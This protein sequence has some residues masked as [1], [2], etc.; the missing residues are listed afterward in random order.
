MEDWRCYMCSHPK[1]REIIG[2]G[3]V[4]FEARFL[5]SVEPNH[6]ELGLPEP[7]GKHR[8]DFVALRA[9]GSACRLHPSQRRDA[10]PVQ[11]LYADWLIGG[12][13]GAPGTGAS[14]PGDLR[15][16]WQRELFGFRNYSHVDI[17]SSEAAHQYLMDV[18]AQQRDRGISPDGVSVDLTE[19][20]AWHRFLMGRDW[21]RKL[22]EEKVMEVAL[23]CPARRWPCACGLLRVRPLATSPSWAA[24][25]RSAAERRDPTPLLRRKAKSRV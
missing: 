20:W 24:A 14:T 21:G 23:S 18:F 8:F 15:M 2:T 4:R 9:D 11:G 7:Y 25:R 3:V 5:N 1:A 13:P 10:L 17:I 22:F 19:S 16:F 6:A 12:A